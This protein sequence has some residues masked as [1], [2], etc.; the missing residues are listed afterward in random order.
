MTNKEYHTQIEERIYNVE[1]KF[2]AMRVESACKHEELIDLLKKYA[3]SIGRAK[4]VEEWEKWRDLKRAQEASEDTISN[5]K[6]QI[7]VTEDCDDGS[8][9]EETLVVASSDEEIV[10]F[11]T[12]PAITEIC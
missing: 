7:F 2:E 1:N 9:P 12:Q 6:S 3:I 8:R 10:K 11:P 4:V 5:S